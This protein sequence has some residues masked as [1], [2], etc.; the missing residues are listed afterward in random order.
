LSN[1]THPR[2]NARYVDLPRWFGFDNQAF[3]QAIIDDPSLI[4]HQLI[5]Q[6]NPQRVEGEKRKWVV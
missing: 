3:E 2:W 4:Y 5:N 6:I 1:D